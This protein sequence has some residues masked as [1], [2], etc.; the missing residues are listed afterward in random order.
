MKTK[1]TIEELEQ[2]ADNLYKAYKEFCVNINKD[3]ESKFD[4]KDEDHEDDYKEDLIMFLKDYLYPWN[5]VET[6]LD[7]LNWLKRRGYII[8]EED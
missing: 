5:D 2:L 6:R 4:I 7:G 1:F 8:N 3:I